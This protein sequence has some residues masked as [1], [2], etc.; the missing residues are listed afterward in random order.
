MI[1]LITQM[2][3]ILAITALL[4]FVFGYWYAHSAHTKKRANSLASKERN[5]HESSQE[6]KEDKKVEES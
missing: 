3:F 4:F 1:Y 6:I 2:G 5:F